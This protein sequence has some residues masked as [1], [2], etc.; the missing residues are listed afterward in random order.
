MQVRVH[1]VQSNNIVLKVFRLRVSI[2]TWSL[3][4]NGGGLMQFYYFAKMSCTESA[5]FAISL[6]GAL[7]NCNLGLLRL[8]LMR[9]VEKS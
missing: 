1:Q 7:E 8:T 5:R 2:N 9:K 4:S 3:G 6:K